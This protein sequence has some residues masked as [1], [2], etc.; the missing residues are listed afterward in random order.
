ME[1]VLFRCI[2]SEGNWFGG[3][4]TE[5]E[6]EYALSFMKDGFEVKSYVPEEYELFSDH[7]K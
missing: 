2:N 1:R 7:N 4:E 5:K 3:F 6:A